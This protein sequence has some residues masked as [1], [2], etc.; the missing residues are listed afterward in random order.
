M[1]KGT[2]AGRA[3]VAIVA[4]MTFLA[5]LTTGAVVLVRAA[6][7]DWQSEVAREVT[8]QVRPVGNRNLELDVTRAADI[9]RAAFPGRRR[10]PGL[11]ARRSRPHTVGALAWNRAWC[12][13]ELPVPRLGRGP[14]I[15]SGAAPE[16]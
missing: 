16:Y 10:C 1:P 14:K 12:S 7:S 11:F 8:I 4:T 6:A 9:A 5:S 13:S 3:L 2:I 15:A